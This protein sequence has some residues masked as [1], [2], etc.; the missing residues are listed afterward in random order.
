MILEEVYNLRLECAR[1]LVIVL[2]PLLLVPQQVLIK[3]QLDNIHRETVLLD[4]VYLIVHV[5]RLV[6]LNVLDVLVDVVIPV[7]KLG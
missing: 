2:L 4:E 1:Q 7:G 6:H 3:L 5:G